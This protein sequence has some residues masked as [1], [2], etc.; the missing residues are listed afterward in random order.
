VLAKAWRVFDQVST[1]TRYDMSATIPAIGFEG[2]VMSAN[3]ENS[4]ADQRGYDHVD[5]DH[6]AQIIAPAL[7]GAGV[8][9]HRV[10]VWHATSRTATCGCIEGCGTDT[11]LTKRSVQ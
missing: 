10:H 7:P 1:R 6:N 11:V 5:R 3:D 8:Q 9:Y 2:L 4:Q